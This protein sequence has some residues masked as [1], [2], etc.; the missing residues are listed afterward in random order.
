[1]AKQ[2]AIL[3][4]DD[5]SVILESLKEQL[6]RNLPQHYELE[7]AESGEEALEVIEELHEEGLEV[8][9]VI[10]DQIMPGLQGDEL[11]IRIHQSYPQMLKIML[12]GQADAQ[13][14]G[15]V[16]NQASLYRYISKPWDET[17]LILTVQEALR[18]YAQE[19]QLVEQN[20]K[21]HELNR[22]LQQLNISLEQKVLERTTQ[23]EQAKQAAEVANQ[24]KSTFLA[25]MS[26]ELRSPLNAILGFA[27]LMNRSTTLSA[28]HQEQ[29]KI[30]LQSG[31]HLL[32]LINQLL[33]LAKIEAGKIT[34]NEA[35][36]DLYHLLQDLEDMFSLKAK[37]QS[38][39]LTFSCCKAVPQYV[40]TDEIKLRQILINLLNNSL[41]FTHQGGVHL[42]VNCNKIDPSN[43]QLIF[44]VQDTGVG[45]DPEEIDQLFEAFTQTQRGR[46]AD[47]GTGLGLSISQKFV[48]LMG[49]KIKVNSQVGVGTTFTFNIH[50][51]FVDDIC[52]FNQ[53]LSRK[54]VG[55]VPNQ[56]AYKILIVDDKFSNRK[57]LMQLLKPLGLELKEASNGKE[58]VEIWDV[59]EPHLILMDLIMPILNGYE[60]TKQIK[61]TLKGNAT[62]IIA[63]TASVLEEQKALVLSMGC[64]DFVRKPFQESHIFE[65]IAKYLGLEYIYAED[66]SLNFLNPSNSILTVES[67]KG[68]PSQ[69][70]DEL[71]QASLDLDYELVLDLIQEIP[72][73]QA[74][75][76][77]ALTDL[78]SNYR[79]DQIFNLIEKIKIHE[80]ST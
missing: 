1:M 73:G 64:D 61:N 70:I 6:K 4:V 22:Q 11:L 24:A 34:L 29:V 53:N 33:D 3:C 60:A 18:R 16:V 59:W 76:S 71:Y 7:S 30:I 78:V 52:L 63:I 15:N 58:A 40:C 55:L 72:L 62:V 48:H 43:L 37:N 74:D 5:E 65:M 41:K 54:I 42:T 75:L 68:M 13:S 27:Q 46:E 47:E 36:F 39:S 17:D 57:L 45:I 20:Q 56:P 79:V 80:Y 9:L 66:T 32:S 12:T 21:L 26:H 14:V 67:L 19:Q 23:L 35:N 31:E 8:A 28:E 44:A 10:S 38:L 77:Q 49:G 25:N 69:W 50:A 51:K 2:L